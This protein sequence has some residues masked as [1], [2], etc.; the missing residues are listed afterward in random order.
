MPAPRPRHNWVLRTLII[1]G[2]DGA[3]PTRPCRHLPDEADQ[4]LT[5]DTARDR[6]FETS[7]LGARFGGDGRES[8]L[9]SR[10]T[11]PARVVGGSGCGESRS[12]EKSRRVPTAAS[13][14]TLRSVRYEPV[15][16]SCGGRIRTYDLEVMSLASYRAAPPRDVDGR[17]LSSLGTMSRGA[18][19]LGVRKLGDG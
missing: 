1:V 16:F 17:I 14:F 5:R 19:R 15:G 10:E 7:G 12:D 18:R 13:W 4:S 2:F 3:M 9:G 6:E 11:T 8:R